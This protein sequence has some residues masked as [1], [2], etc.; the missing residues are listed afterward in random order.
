M[1][2]SRNQVARDWLLVLLLCG[3][4]LGWARTALGEPAGSGD[5]ARTYYLEVFIN[6]AST[7]LIAEFQQT[8]DGRF[9]ARRGELDELGIV[10]PGG[11]DSNEPVAIAPGPGV[12]VRY[13]APAQRLYLELD[14]AHLKT[15]VYD[16]L[17]RNAKLGMPRADYG[18]VLN[19]LLFGAFNEQLSG[20]L[21]WR[22][23]D[24]SGAN[25]TF[26]ARMFGPWG[27][28][29]Q[30]GIVGTS[31]LSQSEALRLETTWTYSD[32][33]SMRT[34]RLGDVISGGLFW[35]RPIRLGG[36][37]VQSNFAL[38]PDLVAQ[39]LPAFT[40]SAAVPSAVDVYVNGFKTYSQQVGA[41]PFRIDNIPLLTG[42]GEARVVLQDSSG[43]RQE[44]TQSFYASSQILRPGLM[45]YSFE[46]GFPRLQFGLRSDEYFEYP[47][48]LAS[49]RLGA[50]DWLT[51]EAHAEAGGGLYNGGAGVVT[52]VGSWGLV[53]LAGI[54][55]AYEGDW[56]ALAHASFETR[57]LGLYLRAS[58]Q[59]TFQGY[60]DL[61]TTT[62]RSD[63]DRFLLGLAAGVPFS[64]TLSGRTP[65]ELDTVSIGMPLKFDASNLSFSFIHLET[66][67]R[68]TSNLLNV[69]YT[70]PFFL[71]GSAYV[72]AFTD[73]NDGRNA[74]IFAGI[75]IPLGG[76][77]F[78]S[79]SLTHTGTSTGLAVETTKAVG[80]EPGSFGWRVRDV[81]GQS[82]YRMA[83]AAYRSAVARFEASVQQ[84]QHHV[85]ATVQAD[86][87]VAAMNGGV[88]FSNGI[89]DAFAVVSTVVPGIDVSFDNRHVGRT[90]ANGRLLVTGL[91]SYQSNKIEIDPRSLPLTAEA[92]QIAQIVTPAD[93]AGVIV[94]FPVKADIN[95]A[96]V[97]LQRKDGRFPA[98]GAEVRRVG[99]GD[100]AVMGYD[101][102]TFLTGLEPNN[103]VLVADSTGECRASFQYHPAPG[104][105]VT[106]GPVLCE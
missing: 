59:R 23:I 37:Q 84:D 43:R 50:Y 56:G 15:R 57:L 98:V 3:I 73:L 19:Y 18:A 39:P 45:Q 102:R 14:D 9:Q 48:A 65:I 90:D 106:I 76:G 69:A 54:A 55:S 52:K 61:A 75:S 30:T 51:L 88:F 5:S 99:A 47:V 16:A 31:I 46:M 21:S 13:D 7:S 68:D 64:R 103:T 87:A 11:G 77:V 35:T 28:F 86:G 92:P 95:A 25:A 81:E 82:E 91:R 96:I 34:H 22:D 27:T 33:A 36:V 58:A 85:R 8:P 6:G 24:F 74:G 79:T 67:E 26:D 12:G 53:S 71:G 60:F 66:Y 41:G 83:S 10:F 17:S 32:P 72:S 101:G 40:G 97:I 89:H 62:A 38:R 42:A 80:N 100:G 105:Q 20:P 63:T 93:R 1:H 94:E 78:A 70:R 29:S 104:S 49:A 44:T 4:S 2:P